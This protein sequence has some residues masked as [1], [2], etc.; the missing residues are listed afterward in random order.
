MQIECYKCREK[1]DIS[2]EIKIIIYIIISSFII[3]SSIIIV[4]V[5][6]SNIIVV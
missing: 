3:L 6:I 4:D 5:I 2:D 1:E